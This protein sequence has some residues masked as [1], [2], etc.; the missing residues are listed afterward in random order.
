MSLHEVYLVL[1]VGSA[2]L[3]VSIAA[4]CMAH[5]AGLPGLLLFMAVDVIVGGD[6][7][8]SSTTRAGSV[9]GHGD[10]A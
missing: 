10:V 5:G 7:M 6:V 3:L 9:V 8:W 1:L 2:V 4:A